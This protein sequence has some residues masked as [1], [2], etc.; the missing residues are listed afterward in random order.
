VPGDFPAGLIGRDDRA[1]ANGRAQVLVSWFG[2]PRCPA[3]CV[4]EA[5][6]RDAQAE[7]LAEQ[8]RDLAQRQPELLIEHDGEDDRFR[9]E[10]RRG[11]TQGIRRLQR[12]ATLHAP[13]APPAA[14]D[15]NVERPH[16][17][18][19]HREIFL[20]LRRM[21][22]Q[23]ERPAA[24]WTLDRQRRLVSLVDVRGNGPVSLAA[25]RGAGLA[26]GSARSPAQRA[27]RKGS[28]LTMNRAS[29]RF[30]F[31]LEAVDLPAKLIAFLTQPV[32]FAA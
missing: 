18:S 3:H 21:T 31:V 11:R 30:K 24:V 26:S 1:A 23:A 29:G 20:I 28:R 22:H 17:R 6:G 27:A 15:R 19:D 7:A 14:A 12:L 2:L 8:R 32:P 13:S 10:L 16:D 4:D 25:I 9:T 5:A